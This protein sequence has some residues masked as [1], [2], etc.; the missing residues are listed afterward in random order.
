[1]KAA[2]LGGRGTARRRESQQDPPYRRTTAEL[3]EQACLVVGRHLVRDCGQGDQPL[4][5]H[6]LQFR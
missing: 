4:V 5:Q 2:V 3:S 1:M 6:R